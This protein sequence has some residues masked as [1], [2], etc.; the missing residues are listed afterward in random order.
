L[1]RG[2]AERFCPILD[3]IVFVKIDPARDATATEMCPHCGKVNIFP[4]WSSMMAYTCRGCGALVR[5]S[6]DPGVERF[7]GPEES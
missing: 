3:L 7:F 2:H 5:L 6:D 4:G 1:V